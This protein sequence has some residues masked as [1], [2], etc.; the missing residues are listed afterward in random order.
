MAF[1]QNFQRTMSKVW[2]MN[3]I[4][5]TIPNTIPMNNNK[6]LHEN[7]LSIKSQ[8]IIQFNSHLIQTILIK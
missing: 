6:S 8:V 3:D 5:N 4:S 1:Q 2:W 7:H